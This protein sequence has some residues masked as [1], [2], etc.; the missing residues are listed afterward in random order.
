MRVV[1][2]GGWAPSLIQFRGPLLAAMA[3]RGHRITAMAPD[4]TSQL[5]DRL[6]AMG[7]TFEDVALQRTGTDALADVR[8]I[9]A[10]VRRLRALEPDLLFTYT[11]KPVVYGNLAAR[12]ARV[13]MRHAMVTGLGYA[14]QGQEHMRRRVLRRA[15]SMMYRAALAGADGLFLQNPDDHRDLADAGALPRDVPVTLV[16]GS[17]VDVDHYAARPFPTGKPRFVY[18]GRLVREKGIV[19][20]VEM[21]RRVRAIRPDVTFTA[22]GWID[23]NPASIGR[24]ELDRWIAD[25]TIE[26]LG[27]VP[28][29]RPVLAEAHV[30]VLPSY[31]E[32]TPRSVLEAMST[33]R[34]VIVT[35]VPGC[36]ETIVDGE[37]GLVVPVRDPAA[38]A[39]AARRMLAD[40][41]LPAMGRAARA[42]IEALYDARTVAAQ[43]LDVMGL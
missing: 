7:V 24:G 34:P 28:D 12:L 13:P 2:L 40:H 36:R 6:A 43:M 15:A 17:G 25:G 5:R 9:A 8:A 3:A 1:V 41:D 42:R 31:R 11:I 32:G 16:R 20:F 26:Y 10:L 21:A 27:D 19:E 22:A 33:G 29:I 30:L 37:H 38:L 39:T 18:V 4:G 14:F 35:D 23:P